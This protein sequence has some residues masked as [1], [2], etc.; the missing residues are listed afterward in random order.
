MINKGKKR[1]RTV[2]G[3]EILRFSIFR[4]FFFS[5]LSSDTSISISSSFVAVL[6]GGGMFK[7]NRKASRQQERIANV[8]TTRRC[9]S[10]TIS[11]FCTPQQ[12]QPEWR[13]L[14][15]FS[16]FFHLLFF[17]PRSQNISLSS[18]ILIIKLCVFGGALA[19]VPTYKMKKKRS[20]KRNVV[21]WMKWFNLAFL[22]WM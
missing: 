9:H 13:A 4:H 16:R 12:Q 19:L 6:R 3:A 22:M 21:C 20:E 5:S 1:S 7:G 14:R 15:E 2:D 17:R 8:D 10:L 18:S 11:F